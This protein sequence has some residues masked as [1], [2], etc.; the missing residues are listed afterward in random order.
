MVAE[1]KKG[2]LPEPAFLRGRCY[3]AV[4]KKQAFGCLP[5]VFSGF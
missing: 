4:T 2:K 5:F 3:A 1:L